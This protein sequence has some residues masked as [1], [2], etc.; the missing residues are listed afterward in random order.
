[1][2]L[3]SIRTAARGHNTRLVFEAPI[4]ILAGPTGAGK[5]T[6]LNC[7]QMALT[8]AITADGKTRS[9]PGDVFDLLSATGEPVSAELDFGNAAPSIERVIA[10][11]P[12]GAC[13]QT[14]ITAG[15]KASK[16]S[17]VEK[18]ISER[19]G[20]LARVDVAGLIGKDPAKRRAEILQACRASA[21][22]VTMP[23]IKEAFGRA[24]A[25]A[26]KAAR[27]ALEKLITSEASPEKIDE[28]REIAEAS[29]PDFDF[30]VDATKG[31]IGSAEA[32]RDAAKEA[33]AAATAEIKRCQQAVD[34]YVAQAN[35]QSEAGDIEAIKARIAELDAE[36]SKVA[37]DIGAA[38]GAQGTRDGIQRRLN[39]LV[40]AG[41]VGEA[42]AAVDAASII[43]AA[44]QKDLTA[45]A[46]PTQPASAQITE[47]HA[48]LIEQVRAQRQVVADLATKVSGSNAVLDRLMV[49]LQAI[50]QG[51]CCPTCSRPMD[52]S[53]R[54]AVQ[55]EMVKATAIRDAAKRDH[56]D[57]A[58]TLECIEADLAAAE[59]AHIAA[60]SAAEIASATAAGRA[61]EA[62][63]T[64]EVAAQNLNA[65]EKRLARAQ[66]AVT[67]REDLR[68]RADAIPVTDVTLLQAQRSA[69][70][71]QRADLKVRADAIAADEARQQMYRQTVVRRDDLQRQIPTLKLAVKAYTAV[72]DYVGQRAV[73]PLVSAVD[74]ALP[75][76]WAFELN[77]ADASFAI[78][79]GEVLTQWAGLSGGE[80]AMALAA[81]AGGMAGV[82]GNKWRAVLID[83]AE[84]IAGAGWRTE[85]EGGL[86]GAFVEGLARA[87]KAGKIDQAI[88]TTNR[89]PVGAEAD[90]IQRAGAV[91]RWMGELAEAQ[92]VLTLRPGRVP[93]IQAD[94]AGSPVHG[95]PA[96]LGEPEF[97]GPPDYL[98]EPVRP[99]VLDLEPP[100]SRG[101][102][103]PR[104]MDAERGAVRLRLNQAGISAEAMEYL[105]IQF[106]DRKD[107]PVS[108]ATLKRVVLEG[109]L[110]QLERGR[111]AAQVIRQIGLAVEAHPVARKSKGEDASA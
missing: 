74:A 81:L 12:K 35:E 75:E 85:Y 98:D 62:R 94:P 42:E 84:A 49:S 51:G 58:E 37:E 52:E 102:A 6:V 65:A 32:R 95:E 96:F 87:V 22:P 13:S 103:E 86:F 19:I 109:A 71:A 2:I 82:G 25:E 26:V 15:V 14:L 50:G 29:P 105:M 57:E 99:S 45:L 4:T 61:R 89:P 104:D 80:R 39:E 30:Q 66:A 90:A 97:M 54:S 92:P 56:D 107:R 91:V 34:T 63:Q 18:M 59:H 17:D 79:R 111:T 83:G 47:A 67:E 70:E 64:V 88:I 73:E 9:K 55:A 68:R 21:T 46:A 23:E 53:A 27:D 33:L 60:R 24:V 76:G 31:L 8:G 100:V 43:Y 3:Q 20:D 110:A 41:T 72:A 44:A 1:M 16:V 77:V 5:T 48:S 38:S 69:A 101:G 40:E 93:L 10:I 28:A 78:R 108:S 106:T 7:V 36:I 11:D